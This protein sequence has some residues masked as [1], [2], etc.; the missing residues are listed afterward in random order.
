MKYVIRETINKYH[1]IDIDDNIN[2]ET[3]MKIVNRSKERYDS[4]IEAVQILCNILNINCEVEPEGA[5]YEIEEIAVE[6]N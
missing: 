2:I 5:G 4:G 3:L 6:Y 1:T